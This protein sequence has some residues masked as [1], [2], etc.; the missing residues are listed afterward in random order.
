MFEW[1]KKIVCEILNKGR[2]YSQFWLRVHSLG[3]HRDNRRLKI[4]NL[5]E[6]LFTSPEIKLFQK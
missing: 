3:S 1:N 4:Q 6:I 2:I 5:L